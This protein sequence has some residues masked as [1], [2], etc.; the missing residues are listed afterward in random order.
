MCGEKASLLSYG[1]F[2]PPRG[3]RTVGGWPLRWPVG[4]H[5]T[6][7]WGDISQSLSVLFIWGWLK[8]FLLRT[9]ENYITAAREKTLSFCLSHFSPLLSFL[10][11]A[12]SVPQSSILPTI[13]QLLLL[14]NKS[15]DLP[16]YPIIPTAVISVDEAWRH[17]NHGAMATGRQSRY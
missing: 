4:S 14:C 10:N 6:A 16:V 2:A 12:L 3:G 1:L 11:T 9:W 15:H 8:R 17:G 7:W 13:L 5:V